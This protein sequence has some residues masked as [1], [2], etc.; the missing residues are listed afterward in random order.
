MRIFFL[1]LLWA[2][3][4]SLCAQ[5]STFDTDNEAWGAD[6]DPVSTIAVWIATNGLP[7]GHIRVTDGATG[8]VWYFVAPARFRGNKCGAYD[9]MLRFDQFTSDTTN[10][11]FANNIPDVEISGPALQLA[12]D[13]PDNPGLEWTHYEIL[14][15]EDA[16]WRI[17]SANG[18]IPTEAQFRSVLANITSIRIKGEYRS[19]ADFGGLDNFVLENNFAFDLDEDNSSGA[20]RGDFRS[21]TLCL[22]ES[23]IADADVALVSDLPIDSMIVR[24]LGAGGTDQLVVGALPPS[25]IVSGAMSDRMV[26]LNGGTATADDFRQTLQSIVYQDIAADPEPG[27]R[28]IAVQA[29]TGCGDM[30][31]NFAYLPVFPPPQV[32]MDGDTTICAQSGSIDLMEVLDGMPE[33][34][35]YWSPLPT[36]GTSRFDPAVDSPGTFQYIVPSVG[37]CP[38]DTANAVVG[39]AFPPVLRADTTICYADTLIL[40]VPDGLLQWQWEDG[41]GQREREIDFPGMYVLTGTTEYCAFT[42][43]IRV[44]FYTC[45]PCFSYAP[46]IFS[47]NDDGENDAWHVFLPCLWQRYRLEIFDRWGSLVFEADD[48]ETSWDGYL[49]GREPV[50]G[51]YIW[52]VEWTGELLGVP[53]TY[54]LS[55]DVTVVR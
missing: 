31:I 4:L 18:P 41:S 3:S 10:Q 43:S 49:K 13:L 5:Q 35:G 51:V 16:G 27:E 36:G 20:Q 21:D 11:I 19:S 23:P 30:G 26:L 22:P 33:N 44:D 54:R 38:G 52:R 37:E 25:I 46:N 8:G 48:P 9:R 28:L 42:D 24:V 29:F 55:G 17:G 2:C 7:G 34:G 14:L 32:G 40:S 12:F 45:D 47:P 53:R 15:R 1:L 39:V 50:P 6:G